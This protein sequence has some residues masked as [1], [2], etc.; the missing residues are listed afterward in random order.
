MSS[1]HRPLSSF[2]Q[3]SNVDDCS[4][5][6]WLAC[7]DCIKCMFHVFYASI[8]QP[9]QTWKVR[10]VLMWG[11]RIHKRLIKSEKS[12]PRG[13]QEIKNSETG[14]QSWRWGTSRLSPGQ[15]LFTSTRVHRVKHVN[16]NWSIQE[17]EINMSGDMTENSE[18]M[19][20]W[21]VK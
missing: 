7:L 4:L 12:I 15:E 2:W 21:R 19:R 5:F 9:C 20:Q 1:I 13:W 18:T 14:Q 3:R 16:I 6:L 11:L 8:S 10:F 17:W